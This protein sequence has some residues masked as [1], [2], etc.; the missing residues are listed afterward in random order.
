MSSVSSGYISYV[1]FVPTIPMFTG[2]HGKTKYAIFSMKLAMYG[3]QQ[4]D[5]RHKWRSKVKNN[6]STWKWIKIFH[7]VE[8]LRTLCSRRRLLFCGTAG[9]SVFQLCIYGLGLQDIL[10]QIEKKHFSLLMTSFCMFKC[11]Q[12]FKYEKVL[13]EHGE[14]PFRNLKVASISFARQDCFSSHI[15]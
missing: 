15:G 3:K 6:H 7:V 14:I 10:F 12:I 2:V 13:F 5:K 9:K 4:D 8:C 11:L 1:P